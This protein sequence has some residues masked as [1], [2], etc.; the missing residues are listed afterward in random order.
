MD[1]LTRVQFETLAV[2]EEIWYIWEFIQNSIDILDLD[3][4]LLKSY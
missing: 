3:L 4:V 1:E 2:F